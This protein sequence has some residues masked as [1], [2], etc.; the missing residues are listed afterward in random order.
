MLINP[1]IAG[2][3]SAIS[4]ALFYKRQWMALTEGPN[5]Y[6]FNIHSPIYHQKIGIGFQTFSEK[7]NIQNRVNVTGTLC[8]RINLAKGGLSFGVST[9]FIQLFVIRKFKY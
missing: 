6:S 1:A 7:Y 9:G 2:S 8:Y 5:I 4:T 3:K